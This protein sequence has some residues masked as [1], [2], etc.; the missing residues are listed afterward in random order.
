M[1]EID[2]PITEITPPHFEEG[3]WLHKR[4]KL[5]YLTYASLDRSQHRDEHV[6]YAT[7][8]SIRGPWTYRGELTGSGKTASR[9]IPDRQF[10][11]EW[12]LFLHNAALT[13]A[14][15]TARSAA[16]RSPSNASI[17]R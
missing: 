14:T 10:K 8:P 1:I 9:S 11:G 12:Y 13:S 16:A 2:G 7:A 17:Q 4:G 5:Y 6:S 15:R 3:P